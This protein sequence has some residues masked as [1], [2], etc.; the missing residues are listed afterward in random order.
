MAILA[1]DFA[2]G[3]NNVLQTFF[4]RA[5]M[6]IPEKFLRARVGRNSNAIR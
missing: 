1:R 5:R 3:S 6:G 4:P 2:R